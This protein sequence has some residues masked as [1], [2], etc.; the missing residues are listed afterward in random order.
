MREQNITCK[1]RC[2]G[3]R[4]GVLVAPAPTAPSRNGDCRRVQSR[5]RPLARARRLE[6]RQKQFGARIGRGARER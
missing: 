3:D 5:R 6:S 2:P 4:M 1:M